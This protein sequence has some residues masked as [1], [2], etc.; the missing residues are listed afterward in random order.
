M[1]FRLTKLCKVKREEVESLHGILMAK[2]SKYRTKGALLEKLL[3]L[4]S[5]KLRQSYWGKSIGKYGG[6]LF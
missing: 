3:T 2:V 1:N 6:K 5:Q 4:C